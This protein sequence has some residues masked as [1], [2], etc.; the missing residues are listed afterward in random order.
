[1]AYYRY[2]YEAITDKTDYLQ[3][4][5]KQ[6]SQNATLV[7]N[8]L[9]F[10][11]ASRA[12]TVSGNPNQVGVAKVGD[13]IILP[14]PSNIQ[15]SNAASYGEDSLD[16]LGAAGGRI[17]MDLMNSGRDLGGASGGFTKIVETAMKNAM[18]PADGA[19][20]FTQVAMDALTRGLAASAINGAIGSNVTAEQLLSRSEGRILNPN[21]ELLFKG[22]TLR[23]FQF[24]FKMTPRDE[25]ESY[26]IKSIIRSFKANMAPKIDGVEG[27]TG[28]GSEFTGQAYLSTPNIFE[29]QYRKGNR[30]HPFLNRFKQCALSSMS[31]NY[32]GEGVYATYADATPVSM[33]LTLAFQELVPIYSSDYYKSISS[34]GKPTEFSD[35]DF[36]YK[37]DGET[38]GVGY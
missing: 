3:I 19:K 35:S 23:Q 7:E 33:I 26:Q 13:V 17:A 32:T 20:G 4:T 34:D 5:V 12:T 14:M 37:K 18:A 1:M 30:N 6:Y 29:L 2:P 24:Q 22:P 36:T 31:V 25:N 15:D 10:G 27:Q 11:V 9:S 28:K 38:E 16:I 8:A 21:M